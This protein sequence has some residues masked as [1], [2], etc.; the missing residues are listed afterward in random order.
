MQINSVRDL[1]GLA[2]NSF[3]QPKQSLRRVLDLNLSLTQA[4]QAGVL[5]VILGMII[6]FLTVL[7]YAQDE[8]SVLLPMGD[9]PILATLIQFAFLL[10]LSA[11]IF[12]V[13]KVFKG[14]GRFVDALIAMSW[15]QF[16]LIG[17]QVAQLLTGLFSPVISAVIFLAG[18]VAMFYMLVQFIMEVHGFTKVMPVI[19]GLFAAFFA[20]AIL[21][22][23]TM[24]LM[25]ITP[26]VVANV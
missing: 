19:A 14:Q 12:I 11:M 5:V 8:Q 2:F 23:I 10:G 4:L 26:E 20:G 3:S 13:G 24:S 18:M 6:P 1:L 7:L 25:G 22:S 16:V 21:L 9:R 15:L 17:F